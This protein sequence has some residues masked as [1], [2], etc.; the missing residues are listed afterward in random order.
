MTANH[1]LDVSSGLHKC[2]CENRIVTAE[3]QTFSLYPDTMV[4]SACTKCV[5]VCVLCV[6]V[7]CACVCVCASKHTSIFF[8]WLILLIKGKVASRTDLGGG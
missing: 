7:V 6:C 4:I 5:C 8:L 2:K 1:P 3:Y